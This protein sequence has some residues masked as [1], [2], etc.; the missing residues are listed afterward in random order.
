MEEVELFVNGIS[1]G[2]KKADDHFFRFEVK[3]VGES[4]IEAVSGEYKDESV[5]RKVDVFNEAYRLKEEGQII[6]WFEITTKEGK[7]SIKDK[8][9]D[10]MKTIRGKLILFAFMLKILRKAKKNDKSG[11]GSALSSKGGNSNKEA[12][13]KMLSSFTIIRIAGMIGM[14]GVTLTKKDLLKLNKKLNRIKKK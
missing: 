1:I 11:F 7:L 2:K 8:I 3:N 13:M 9:G 10:I 4:K 5:I 6:N 12:L 14:M